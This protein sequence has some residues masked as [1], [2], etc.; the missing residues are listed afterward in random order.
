MDFQEPSIKVEVVDSVQSVLRSVTV[1]ENLEKELRRLAELTE[2]EGHPSAFHYCRH[3]AIQRK[4]GKV[5]L[6]MDDR[7]EV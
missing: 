5:R 3:G 7:E 6:A 4:L 1:S 2:K